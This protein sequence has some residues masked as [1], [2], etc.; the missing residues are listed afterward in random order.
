MK[1]LPLILGVRRAPAAGTG[2]G[3]VSKSQSDEI[4]KRDNYTCRFCGFRSLQYQRAISLPPTHDHNE[5]FVTACTF[6][7]NALFLDRAGIMGAGIL[8]W[9]PEIGQAELN[10]LA[11]AIYVARADAG[12]LAETANRALDT[13]LAR[14]TEAKKRVASDDPLVL[15]TVM[16]ENLD[17]SAYKNAA[18]KLEGVRLMPMDKYI[19]RGKHGDINQ[20]SQMVKFWSS[21]QGPYGRLPV[22]QWL[23]LFQAAQ[24]KIGHA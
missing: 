3:S 9:L 2:T 7:E 22:D 5:A 21:P 11:R 20:F 10:H 1:F 4:L 12:G 6:C 13:L 16:H 23:N 18:T 17:D 14:R 8:V 24:S 15:A 19:V